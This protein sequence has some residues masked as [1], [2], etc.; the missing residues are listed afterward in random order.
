M[1]RFL[2]AVL[3]V[4]FFTVISLADNSDFSKIDNDNDGKIS[5]KEYI[6]AVTK[7]FDTLDKNMDGFL[8]REELNAVGKI[9][10]RKLVKEDDINKDGKVSK[11]EFGNA[12]EK[13]FKIMDKNNDG[14][15]D[16]QEWNAAKENVSGNTSK[17]SP[18]APFIIFIF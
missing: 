4:L 10:Y 17:I 8:T 15:I 11:E 7:T 13:K 18:V 1:K 9:H 16:R 3:L 5:K 12:S 14:F 6:N 2:T